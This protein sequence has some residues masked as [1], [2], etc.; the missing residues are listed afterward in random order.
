LK[1]ILSKSSYIRSL[2]CLKSLYFYKFHYKERD[3]ISEEQQARFD[4][5]HSYGKLAHL[6]F[7]GGV[8]VSPPTPWDYA[9]AVKQT[10]TLLLKQ[11]PVIYEASFVGDEVVVA[12]D[13]LVKRRGL[14]AF[15]V[16]SSTVVSETILNDAALQYYVITQSGYAL[17]DFSI[18]HLR[19]DYK[20]L[21]SD[22]VQ[23]LFMEQSVKAWCERQL[24]NVKTNIAQAKELIRKKQLPVI[25]QGDHCNKPY[26]CGFKNLCDKSNAFESGTLFSE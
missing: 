14:H 10:Q 13:I 1:Y 2:Q 25:A 5:G 11:Q 23:A 9:P 20:E 16:K 7:P 4:R 26:P 15:E 24:D 8:D 22:N 18:I 3:P 17:E 21:P 19:P 12:L 6:L